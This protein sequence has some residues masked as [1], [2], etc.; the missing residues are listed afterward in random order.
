MADNPFLSIGL[1][2]NRIGDYHRREHDPQARSRFHNALRGVIVGRHPNLFHNNQHMQGILQSS[3]GIVSTNPDSPNLFTAMGNMVSNICLSLLQNISA[4]PGEPNPQ[5]MDNYVSTEIELMTLSFLSV[6]DNN[7]HMQDYL[8]SVINQCLD[9]PPNNP[10]T[11]APNLGVHSLVNQPPSSQHPSPV[12]QALPHPSVHLPPSQQALQRTPHAGLPP[13]VPALPN[14][15]LADALPPSDSIENHPTEPNLQQLQ[16]LV[17]ELQ[18]RVEAQSLPPLTVPRILPY[19]SRLPLIL[20]ANTVLL[21]I[22]MIPTLL[23]RLPPL[24]PNMS[25]SV[26][27]PLLLRLF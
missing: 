12:S 22:L 4:R 3:I 1:L 25:K 13:A 2:L 10:P 24:Q 11:L 16:A 8:R 21:P 14:L 6:F 15:N 23:I 19:L 26:L 17:Q 7:Q 5:S 18:A 27:P 20:L 9:S